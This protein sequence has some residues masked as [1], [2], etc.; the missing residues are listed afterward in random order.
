MHLPLALCF[1]LSSA[2]PLPAQ[3]ATT[4]SRM[5]LL[6]ERLE[7][8]AREHLDAGGVVRRSD[9]AFVLGGIATIPIETVYTAVRDVHGMRVAHRVEVSSPFIGTTRRVTEEIEKN[10]EVPA[11]AW[12]D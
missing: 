3:E 4:E 7:E 8:L 12:E 11:T 10:V 5:E 6:I 2:A 9:A 1:L